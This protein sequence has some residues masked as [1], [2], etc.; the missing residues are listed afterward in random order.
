LYSFKSEY[1]LDGNSIEFLPAYFNLIECNLKKGQHAEVKKYLIVG[2]S[3]LMISS[4]KKEDSKDEGSYENDEATKYKNNLRSRLDLLFARFNMVNM[5][6]KLSD[7]IDKL[8]NSII[9]YSE[10]YGPES[11][12]LTVHYFYLAEYFSRQH[13]EKHENQD[14]RDV[15]MKNIFLKIADNWK[16]FFIGD[17][18][19]LFECNIKIYII[20]I[21]S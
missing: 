13:F 6:N 10:I 18:N 19:E 20:P 17:K 11:V 14:S 12:G 21:C 3:N 1:T 9:L 15:I 2:L 16:K 8:T 4:K 7:A 5:N